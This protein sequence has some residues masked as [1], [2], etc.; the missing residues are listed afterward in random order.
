M[1]SPGFT[2]EAVLYKTRERY[3]GTDAFNGQAD[4]GKVLPQCDIGCYLNCIAWG[5]DPHDC[6]L[7]CGCSGRAPRVPPSK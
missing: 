7:G 3:N 1:R 5:N 6:W 2:A 4:S